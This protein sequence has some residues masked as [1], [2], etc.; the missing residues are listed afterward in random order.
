MSN[1]KVVM[2]N[3]SRT[4][5]SGSPSPSDNGGG[6]LADERL[7]EAVDFSEGGWA[8]DFAASVMGLLFFI[9]ALL[10]YNDEHDH[11]QYMHLGTFLAHLFGGLA[12][13]FY[14]NRASDGVG[15]RGFY[16]SMLLGYSGNCLRYGLGWGLDPIFGYIAA[17]NALYLL[18]AGIYVMYKME[19][20]SDLIDNAEG[21]SF[22]PDRIFGAGEA[23]CSTMEVV[24]SIYYLISE[25]GFEDTPTESSRLFYVAV[26]ANLIGWAAVYLFA[27]LYLVCGIDYDPSLKQRIFHYCMLIMLWA[28]DS[29]VRSDASADSSV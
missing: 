27:F 9:S 10:F 19:H 15:H 21:I 3:A 2:N 5:R 25:V 22:V 29:A 20:T 17:A 4:S 24:A 6:R 7:P 8:T 14:P 13:R 23:L 12:H 26:A 1:N 28:I 18:G 16:I 11:F